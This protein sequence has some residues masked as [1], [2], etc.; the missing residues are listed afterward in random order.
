[1]EANLL[2]V[3]VRV[4]VDDDAEFILAGITFDTTLETDD[5]STIF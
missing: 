4:P 2:P 5:R 1:V 3:G